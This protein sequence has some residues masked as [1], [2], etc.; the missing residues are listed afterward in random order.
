MNHPKEEELIAFR[1]GETVQREAIAEHLKTCIRCAEELSRIDALLE[2]LNTI[3]VPEPTPNFEQR[4]WQQIAPKLQEKR[5]SWWTVWLEPR[6]LASVAAVA[7]M[8]L[9][10]FYVGRKSAPVVPGPDA[11]NAGQ[12]RE[13]VLVVAVGEHLGRSEMMLM[14]L[15]NAEPEAGKAKQVD[16]SNEQRRAEDLL[17]ENRLYRQT[18]MHDGDKGL[19]S[20]LDDLERVLTDVAHSP[21]EISEAQLETIRQRIEARGLLFKVRVVSKELQ[22]RQK[23]PKPQPEPNQSQKKEGNKA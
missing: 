17:Q 9:I 18:A 8:L 11:L 14:E 7:T 2:V 4:I 5:A 10:A 13:R 1:D 19:A 3:P 23:S 22:D 12:V 21:S 15:S 6:R 16:I 20:V